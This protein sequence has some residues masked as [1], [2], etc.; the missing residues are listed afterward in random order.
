MMKSARI[1]INP[2]V[3][4][5]VYDGDNIRKQKI[6]PEGVRDYVHGIGSQLLA[7]YDASGATPIV[8]REYIYLGSRLLAQVGVSGQMS[9]PE[10]ANSAAKSAE[11]RQGKGFDIEAVKRDALARLQDV[12][13]KRNGPRLAAPLSAAIPA[14]MP[15][16]N[17]AHVEHR[18]LH[19]DGLGPAERHLRAC[20]LRRRW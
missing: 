5:Y 13:R 11:S 17:V 1:G 2:P 3:A 14:G 20:G 9:A 16:P 4:E 8:L 12:L 19:G 7:E 10:Q 15:R 18:G 6:T